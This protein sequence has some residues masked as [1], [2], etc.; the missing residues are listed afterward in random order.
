MSQQIY[1][2]LKNEEGVHER[3]LT[4]TNTHTRYCKAHAISGFLIKE[5][6]F[7]KAFLHA[8]MQRE[9]MKETF[10]KA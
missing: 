3:G 7:H 9:K 2:I 8:C 6:T 10:I 4:C 1:I 5:L